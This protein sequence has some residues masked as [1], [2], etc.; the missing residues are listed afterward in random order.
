MHQRLLL[1]EKRLQKQHAGIGGGSDRLCQPLPRIVVQGRIAE[2]VRRKQDVREMIAQVVADDLRDFL[3][4]VGDPREPVARLLQIEMGA[5]PRQ[6]FFRDEGLGDV[7][8]RARGKRA[9]QTVA[10]VVGGEK[11]HRHIAGLRQRL[12]SGDHLEAVETGHPH[13]QQHQIGRVALGQCERFAAI[14][15]RHDIVVGV[16]QQLADDLHIGGLVVDHHHHRQGDRRLES[17]RHRHPPRT[18]GPA[19]RAPS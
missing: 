16:G 2:H 6:Q 3:A 13:V 7:V 14:E 19:D 8:D 1:V 11:D 4:F 12:Q 15:Y 18:S 9:G 5:H 10:L 17:I